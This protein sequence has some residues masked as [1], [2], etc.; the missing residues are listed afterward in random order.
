MTRT[1]KSVTD[2]VN[3]ESER[4]L[5]Y[6]SIKRVLEAKNPYKM[7]LSEM[8]EAFATEK[9]WN[10]W[11]FLKENYYLLNKL[12][13]DTGIQEKLESEFKGALKKR[14]LE[15]FKK[16]VEEEALAEQE[17][18]EAEIRKVI[19]VIYTDKEGKKVSYKRA[20]AHLYNDRQ[21]RFILSR[22]D[23]KSNILL[24]AEFNKVFGTVISKWGIRDR[25]YRLLKK[26]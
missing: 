5:S 20:K 24:A 8:H 11:I 10:L 3:E 25:K 4:I 12:F 13:R 19:S 18:I 1:P 23:Y 9:G 15:I 16:A 14:E 21:N 6:I 22:A 26:K 17:I 7:F 2:V